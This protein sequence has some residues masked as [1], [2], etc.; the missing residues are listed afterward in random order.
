M[1]KC[2]ICKQELTKENTR[3]KGE[4]RRTGELVCD[5]CWDYQFK[6]DDV[7]AEER[8]HRERYGY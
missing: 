7:V 3:C 5:G 6:F 1:T 2:Y 8:E 4:D